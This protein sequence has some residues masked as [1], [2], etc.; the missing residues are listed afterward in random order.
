MN[1]TYIYFYF[2]IISILLWGCAAEKPALDITG[3]WSGVSWQVD[4]KDANRNASSVSF[5]FNADGS[6]RANMGAQTEQ[7]VFN[8]KQDKLFTTAD[9]Q[10]KKMVKIKLRGTDTLVMDMNRVGTGEQLILVKK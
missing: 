2:A 1:K 10:L 3:K 6:Y 8:I 9:G 5:E 7:G 4:G